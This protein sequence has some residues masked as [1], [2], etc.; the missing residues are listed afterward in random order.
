MELEYVRKEDVP[1]LWKYTKWQAVLAEFTASGKEA[2]KIVPEPERNVRS[3][4]STITQ[5]IKRMKVR[6]MCIS[7]GGIIYLIKL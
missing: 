1:Q 2:M 3:M 4:Q 5:A 6:V 7:R